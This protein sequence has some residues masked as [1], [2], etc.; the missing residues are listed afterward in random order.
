[1]LKLQDK[2]AHLAQMLAKVPPVIS[3]CSIQTAV[4][5]KKDVQKACKINQQSKPS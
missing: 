5:Y 2:K 1:M 3:G 4:Q